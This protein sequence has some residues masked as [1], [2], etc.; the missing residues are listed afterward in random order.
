LPNLLVNSVQSNGVLLP[1]GCGT[2]TIQ[3][4]FLVAEIMHLP[5]PTELDTLR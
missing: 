2:E 1:N 3:P 5:T 4:P